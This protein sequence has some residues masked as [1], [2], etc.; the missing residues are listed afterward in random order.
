MRIW[1]FEWK[2]AAIAGCEAAK[3]SVK[4]LKKNMHSSVLVETIIIFIVNWKMKCPDKLSLLSFGQWCVYP[5]Y[6][7]SSR[8]FIYTH[9]RPLLSL[10]LLF[11]RLR[12]MLRY[13]WCDGSEAFEGWDAVASQKRS[14]LICQQGF[15]I[16]SFMFAWE[17]RVREHLSKHRVTLSYRFP[18]PLYTYKMVYVLNTLTQFSS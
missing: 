5:K 14:A 18:L 11:L 9:K 12:S 8:L 2:N 13:S 3:L 15:I 10:P 7:L 4:F 17:R 1:Y 6:K 16:D